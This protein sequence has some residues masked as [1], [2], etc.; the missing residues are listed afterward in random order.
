MCGVVVGG[1]VVKGGACGVDP[2]VSVLVS[3]SVCWCPTLVVY[4]V[5]LLNGGWCGCV[6]RLVLGCVFVCLRVPCFP[7][8]LASPLCCVWLVVCWWCVGG[9]EVRCVAVVCGCLVVFCSS[10]F[11]FSRLSVFAWNGGVCGVCGCVWFSLFVFL[12]SSLSSL[13][14]PLLLLVFG[15]VRAQLCEHARYPRTPLL[16]LLLSLFSS[17]PSASRFSLLSAFPRPLPFFVL[18]WRCVFTM[19]RCVVLA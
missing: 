10:V 9:G 13:S 6:V 1:V 19:C 17:L 8:C 5:V 7:L 11:L 4:P 14:F 18:E 2:P 15:V 16:S 12:L 3:P